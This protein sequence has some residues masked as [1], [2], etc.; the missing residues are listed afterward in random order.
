MDG[1]ALTMHAE[2]GEVQNVWGSFNLGA[3]RFSRT[4][5]EAQKVSILNKRG[6][7]KF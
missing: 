2:V 3:R 5:W 7:E 4:E 1:K 6:H